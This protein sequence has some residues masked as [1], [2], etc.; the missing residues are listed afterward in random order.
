MNG[1]EYQNGLSLLCDDRR[2][3]QEL[4]T[5][6][7][8]TNTASVLTLVSHVSFLS[9]DFLWVWKTGWSQL[10]IERE[11]LDKWW[12]ANCATSVTATN[13]DSSGIRYTGAFPLVATAELRAL[14]GR[15]GLPSTSMSHYLSM[16]FFPI[17]IQIRTFQ[18]RCN[19]ESTCD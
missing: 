18:F 4:W 10:D 2:P 6:H 12:K 19:S 1:P 16:N 7:L 5:R 11:P 3:V 13:V 8:R 14:H 9:S 15:S 17:N